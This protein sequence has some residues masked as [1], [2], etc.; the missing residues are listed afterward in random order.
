M[1]ENQHNVKKSIWRGTCA[2]CG[3]VTDFLSTILVLVL[4]ITVA[5][6]FYIAT[7]ETVPVPKF[8]LRQLES[9]LESRGVAI[10]MKSVRYYFDGSIILESP[11]VISTDFNSQVA[12]A[13]LILIKVRTPLLLFGQVKVASIS[14][15]NGI[16][17]LPPVISPSGTAVNLIEDLDFKIE[18]SP[19]GFDL[20]YAKLRFANATISAS[21][22]FN[23]DFITPK[24]KKEPLNVTQTILKVGPKIWEQRSFI[25]GIE[26]PNASLKFNVTASGEQEV[27]LVSTLGKSDLKQ[28]VQ[29]SQ[30]ILKA[31]GTYGQQL[32]AHIE[33]DSLFA[34]QSLFAQSVQVASQWDDFPTVKDWLPSRSALQINQLTKNNGTLPSI[35]AIAQKTGNKAVS[36]SSDVAVS[37]SVWTLETELDLAQQSGTVKLDALIDP[38]TT[39][40]A[41][42]IID[43]DLNP[44]AN[45]GDSVDLDA[46]IT[47]SNFKQYDTVNASFSSGQLTSLGANFDRAT[48]SVR[49]D[50]PQINV[51][52]IQIRSGAQ[53]GT[54]DISLN[55]ESLQRRFLI[56]GFL[57]P[58]LIN[59]WFPPWWAEIWSNFQ[60]PD[61]GIYSLLDSR[62]TIKQPDSVRVTGFASGQN[63]GI[64]EQMMEDIWLNYFIRFYYLDFYNIE[65]QRKEGTGSGEAQIAMARDPR[66]GIEK[67]TALWT[68]A[69][70]DFDI[71][72]GDRLIT[73]IGQEIR[74]ILEP[75]TYDTPGKIKA[76]ARSIR[77][78]DEFDYE[79]D[80]NIDTAHPIT[81]FDF[82]FESLQ[83]DVYVD[84]SIIDIKNG[85]GGIAGGILEADAEI[86]DGIMTIDAAL[87]ESNFGGSLQS[88][89]YYFEASED[90]EEI[91][92][93]E[94]PLDIESLAEYEGILNATFTGQGLIGDA[95]SYTGTGDFAITEAN[96]AKVQ[97]FGLL[98]KALQATPLRFSTLKFSEA[99]GDFVA[100]KKFIEF[101]NPRV[102]GPVAVI[103][104]SGR[105]DMEA[106]DL[107][108]KAK[109]FPFRKSKMPITFLLG[110]ALNPVSR[111]MEVKLSGEL[112][113]PNISIFNQSSSETTPEEPLEIELTTE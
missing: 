67:M 113:D 80:V 78:R 66:D 40:V 87:K 12:S 76:K 55:Q 56:E 63:V 42:N 50:G 30:A 70:A 32:E 92:P 107:D 79:V 57:D 16:F 3:A 19:R 89:A 31:R 13:D 62:S 46:L 35:F 18:Q 96:L 45:L 54:I 86:T 112:H 27:Q 7:N 84:N 25:E 101:P 52:N 82:P 104:S 81:V 103:E 14:L 41:T 69:E 6:L 17:Q 111:F 9:Q 74:D 51:D 106:D 23:T 88:A 47:F 60:F 29:L 90:P 94:E 73:E 65:L 2:T 75:Y 93:D 49:I 71:K 108:V 110:V 38:D 37:N 10:R 68:D 20:K 109:L 28:T 98:S 105:Y 83:A 36:I 5:C 99:S 39:A 102:S 11:R 59:G 1:G 21:G 97:M 64:R 100:N 58:N 95:F 26:N 4:A 77:F 61:S 43:K 91:D 8:V 44:F 72:I 53:S 22:E 24:G 34:P 15:S 48:G 33:A 85:R